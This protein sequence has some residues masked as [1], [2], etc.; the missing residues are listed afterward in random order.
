MTIHDP[1][2]LGFGEYYACTQPERPESIDTVW[3]ELCRA[4]MLH[5]KASYI[6]G[7]GQ[8]FVCR[9]I[10]YDEDETHDQTASQILRKRLV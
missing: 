9:E 8:D 6:N 7:G 3:E 1:L 10:G 2:A 5:L 4:C